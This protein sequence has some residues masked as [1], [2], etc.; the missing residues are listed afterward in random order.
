MRELLIVYIFLGWTSVLAVGVVSCEVR[1]VRRLTN[2][3]VGDQTGCG[4]RG[5]EWMM[6]YRPEWKMS[7]SLCF[8]S[9]SSKYARSGLTAFLRL[10][11]SGMC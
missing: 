10:D 4:L 5:S 1:F 8:S 6:I 2:Y 7:G 11:Q 9:A 3:F